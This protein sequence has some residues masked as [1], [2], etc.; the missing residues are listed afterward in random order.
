MKVH[1]TEAQLKSLLRKK[2]IKEERQSKIRKNN[3]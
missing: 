1:I 2:I 3:K